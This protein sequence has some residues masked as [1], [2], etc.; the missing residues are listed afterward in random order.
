M[1]II[2]TI[3]KKHN[4]GMFWG[5]SNYS[6]NLITCYASTVELLENQMRIQLLNF[7]GLAPDS[8]EFVRK[9]I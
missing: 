7:E 6:G 4:E 5:S 3:E 1:K 8:V 9:F 2:L